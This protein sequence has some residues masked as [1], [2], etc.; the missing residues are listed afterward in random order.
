MSGVMSVTGQSDGEPLYVGVPI[1]DFTAAMVGIQAVLLGLMARHTTGRGQ[2]VDVSMLNALTSS[3]T[4]RL[5]SWWYGDEVPTRHGNEHSVVAPY[6]A[7]KTADGYVVAGVWGRGE[8]WPRFCEA[9]GREDLV[10]QPEFA[11]NVDRVANRRAL[12]AILDEEFIKRTSG[13][14]REAFHEAHALFGPVLS[15]PEALEQEQI[16]H[17]GM[18]TSIEHP[19]L[20]E[21]PQL[22]PVIDL[23]ETPGDIGVPPPLLGQHT[24]E[25]LEELGYSTEEIDRMVADSVALVPSA[26]DGF[27]PAIEDVAAQASSA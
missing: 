4:T 6:Q 17:Q 9:I 16:A 13:E 18:V 23:K 7:F 15:I 25:V 21:I 2:K 22:R 3:L 26:V 19:T 5:A 20:G 14:W 10:H 1:A 11:T 27:E 12:S 8:A 24:V